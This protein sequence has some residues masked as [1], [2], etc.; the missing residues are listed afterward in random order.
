[1][2][3]CYCPC[4]IQHHLQHTAAVCQQILHHEP[5]TFYQTYF[6]VSSDYLVLSNGSGIAS[7]AGKAA[8][9]RHTQACRHPADEHC[10]QLIVWR[11]L[12]MQTAIAVLPHLLGVV[13]KQI[14]HLQVL[15]GGCQLLLLIPQAP[16]LKTCQAPAVHKQHNS[17][18]TSAVSVSQCGSSSGC[19]LYVHTSIPQCLTL[20][21]VSASLARKPCCACS[22]LHTMHCHAW[23]V[24]NYTG[25]CAAVVSFPWPPVDC[26]SCSGRL[27]M[28]PVTPLCCSPQCHS[29]HALSLSFTQ[30]K[31]GHQRRL[32][33]RTISSRTDSLHNQCPTQSDCELCLEENDE[34]WCSNTGTCSPTPLLARG[35]TCMIGL[36][37]GGGRLLVLSQTRRLLHVREAVPTV[38]NNTHATYPTCTTASSCCSASSRPST[39]CSRAVAFASACCA[40]R[41]T[42]P[43]LNSKKCCKHSLKL[44]VLGTP[45]TRATCT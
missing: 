29:E 37:T 25:L 22:Q 35:A 20:L 38:H 14:T 42:T 26:S 39:R 10:C 12:D 34:T 40:R 43:S 13:Q 16:S 8:T 24:D 11:L 15:D 4:L 28:A 6:F 41:C 32:S 9:A 31:A 21:F 23:C 18:S 2:L 7:G 36:P 5:Q 17:T 19:I 27:P 1:M 30:P 45:F 44:S 3:C 33:C